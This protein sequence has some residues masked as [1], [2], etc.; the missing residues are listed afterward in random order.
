MRR[1]IE[2]ISIAL[3]GLIVYFTWHYFKDPAK[4]ESQIKVLT[5]G[6]GFLFIAYKVLTGWLFINLTVNLESKRETADTGNDHLALAISLEKG[7]IDS[8]WVSAVECR[9]SECNESNGTLVFNNP[10]TLE[11]FGTM[12]KEPGKIA[13]SKKLDYFSGNDSGLIVLSPNEKAVFSAYTTVNNASVISI[14]IV[15]MG[16]RPFYGIEKWGGKS[17]QWRSSFI[18]L[19][20]SKNAETQARTL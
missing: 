6:A 16:N 17:I 12:K 18:V 14:E 13:G 7:N 15:V 2:F 4:V 20:Q 11:A 5:F 1:L 9:I 8:L 10:K 19:P 3:G